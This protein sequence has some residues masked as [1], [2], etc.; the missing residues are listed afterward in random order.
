MGTMAATTMVKE[1]WRCVSTEHL[2]QSVTWAGTSW[3]PKWLA[4]NLVLTVS[5]K[6]PITSVT[7]FAS[8]QTAIVRIIVPTGSQVLNSSNL[9][10]WYGSV[11]LEN[12]TCNGTERFGFQCLTPGPGVVTSPE[13]YYPDRTAGVRCFRSELEQI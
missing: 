13:C 8:S 12:V 11:F 7:I 1:E 9:E 3:M 2:E 6:V 5:F 10:P 4:V